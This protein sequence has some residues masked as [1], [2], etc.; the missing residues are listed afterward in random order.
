[1]SQTN[2]DFI[3]MMEEEHNAAVVLFPEC[4]ICGAKEYTGIRLLLMPL[5]FNDGE[6][7]YDFMAT[8]VCCKGAYDE[9]KLL[10]SMARQMEEQNEK[11]FA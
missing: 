5:A 1:M 6:K 10:E 11:D 3:R 4:V 7:S 9:R 2:I 8:L